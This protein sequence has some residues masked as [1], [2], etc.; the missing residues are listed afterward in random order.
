MCNGP[1]SLQYFKQSVA[2]AAMPQL[3][4]VHANAELYLNS[5]AR[6][7]LVLNLVLQSRVQEQLLQ[8]QVVEGKQQLLVALLAQTGW[9][10]VLWLLQMH[11][12]LM[13]APC[14]QMLLQKPWGTMQQHWRA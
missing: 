9:P 1:A 13:M 6:L 5:A 4:Q 12:W 10:L 7:L 8:E 14:P 3:Q 2:D 11:C